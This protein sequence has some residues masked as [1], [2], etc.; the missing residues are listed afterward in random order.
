VNRLLN[1]I[2]RKYTPTPDDLVAEYYVEPNGVSLERAAEQVAAESSIGTWTTISTMNPEIATK[3][4]PSVFSI[5]R[6]KNLIKVAY[7]W[8][9][10]EPGN[11]P[12]IYSAIAGNIFGMNMVNNLR[13]EDIQFPKKLVKSFKGPKFGIKGIRKLTRIKE[14]PLVGTI[15]KPKVGL[16]EEGHA[17]VAYESWMGGLDVVKDDENL[18]SMKFNKFEERV[19]RTLEARDRAELETGEKKIYMPNVTADTD[20][21]IKRAEFVKEQGGEYIMIDILTAGWS[22]L[23]TLRDMDFGM[24]IHA[25]RAMHAAIT[26]DHRHGV[27]MLTIAK[28]SRLIGCDQLHI[29]TAVG[30]MDGSA[31][32]IMG[33]EREIEDDLIHQNNARKM[34][35]QDWFEMKPTLAVCS[36]GLHIGMMPKLMRLMGND[37]VAQFG[38]GCHWHP[39]GTRYGAMGI[40]Q[41]TEALM[42]KK[43]LDQAAKTNKELQEAISK[44]GIVK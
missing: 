5:D 36:G 14:R 37:I 9:L 39:E 26:R 27:S 15:V 44:F 42:A 7:N 19:L 4:K 2:D 11:M 10:F 24:V 21:M 17:K 16:H 34:L 6:K 23:Q 43:T 33:I 38:G 18:T 29:G 12:Q 28:T 40:R 30:K 1:Y 35:D 32:E 8:E 31:E 22:A 20:T 25:H 13:L 41:G 3:L